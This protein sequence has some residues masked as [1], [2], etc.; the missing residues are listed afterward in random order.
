M[1]PRSVRRL[2]NLTWPNKLAYAKRWGYHIEDATG[3]PVAAQF[4]REA[5]GAGAGLA[6]VA[7]PALVAASALALDPVQ[8]A[9][10][11]AVLHVVLEQAPLRASLAVHSLPREGADIFVVAAWGCHTTALLLV[12]H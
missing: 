8:L 11:L 6:L 7:R 12:R 2:R 10:V 9:S 4:Y 3:D 1:Q 5:A